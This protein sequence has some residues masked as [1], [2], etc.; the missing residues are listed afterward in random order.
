MYDDQ[1]KK[2]VVIGIVSFGTGC[3]TIGKA[4]VYAK[5]NHVLPWIK[6]IMSTYSRK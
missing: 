1:Q 3:G 5:V 4:A 2:S 6:N